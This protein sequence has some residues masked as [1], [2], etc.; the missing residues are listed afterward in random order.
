MSKRTIY[1]MVK[2]TVD[3]DVTVR[4]VRDYLREA[5]HHW[6]G[7]FHPEDPLFTTNKKTAV[8]Y[9]GER[10]P[11]LWDKRLQEYR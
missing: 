11:V 6:G 4:E 7:Q 5:V 8:P 1:A 10:K 3:D 2:V 9:C